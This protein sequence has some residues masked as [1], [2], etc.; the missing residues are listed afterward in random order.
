MIHYILENDRA[1]REYV[2]HFTNARGDPQRRRPDAG[3]PRRLVLRLEARRGACT[4]SRA[5]TTTASTGELTAGKREQTGDVSGDQAH[6]AHGMELEHG[7][8]PAAGPH[9]RAPALRVPD[10]APPL[11]AL[12]AGD[13][14]GD[15]RR[16]AR[17]LHRGRRGA[18]R[19]LGPR[20]HVGDL[21][22]GRLDAAHHGVQNIR[23][24]S[25]IQ[26]LLGNIGRPGGGILA[27]R[28]HANIQGST[29]IPTLYDILPS[30]IPMPH[31]VTGNSLAEFV[32]KTGPSTGVWGELGAYMTSLLKAWWGEHATADND[33][34]LSLPA[35]DRRRLL[36]T[37]RWRSRCSTGIRKGY[38]LVGQNPVVGNAE[39]GPARQGAG[40]PR[41]ARRA[42]HGRDRVGV[43]LARLEARSRPA[44]SRP[45]RSAPRS[46]S[47]PPPRTRRRTARSRTR[48]GCCSGTTRRSS[49]ARTAARSCGS[50]T[51]SAAASA[52]GSPRR[53]IRAISGAA[54]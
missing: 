13:G 44:S 9:A 45:T 20:A 52:R 39:L 30:Y 12:H 29:D 17:A 43:V 35:D 27:L 22:R 47:C 48:S 33:F 36:G 4:R 24:A 38:F 14:R 34:C 19:E 50:P 41:L 23:A 26:L 15:L 46:S 10:A 49:R 1:F 2:T 3:G 31:P 51:S 40:E 11:R 53:T 54:T 18:V 37:T 32:E 25:I 16:P 21:L 7:E 6:G 42:R 8:P 28:G 5:G